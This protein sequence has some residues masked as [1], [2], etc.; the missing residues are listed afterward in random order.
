MLMTPQRGLLHIVKLHYLVLIGVIYPVAFVMGVCFV[1]TKGVPGQ[2]VALYIFFGNVRTQCHFF[3][4][5]TWMIVGSISNCYWSDDG[6]LFS[7][8]NEIFD[9]T[10]FRTRGGIHCG[11]SM[12]TCT[13]LV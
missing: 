10:S 9:T 11:N 2:W 8:E 3:F 13:Y 4:N 7:R 6:T 1:N 5:N 12:F